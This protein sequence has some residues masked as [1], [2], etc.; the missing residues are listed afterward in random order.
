MSSTDNVLNPFDPPY[1]DEKSLHRIESPLA[2]A[3]HMIKHRTDAS[4]D[5]FLEEHIRKSLVF[6]AW[7]R[8]M[9]SITPDV[10]SRYQKHYR[11]HDRA[12]VN[13]AVSEMQ[14][15]LPVGQVLFHGGVWPSE[16]GKS[17]VLDRPFA[18]TLIPSVALRN[19][20]CNAKAYDAG[21]I[22]LM[23]LTIRAPTVKAFVFRNRRTSQS[24]EHE[25]LLSSG[26]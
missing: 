22:Q 12:A 9:P 16:R 11:K 1:Q 18:T 3:I 7:R 4:L 10:L 15:Y 2:A 23:V 25:V 21:E 5:F 19:A 20:E 14:F 17:F 24:H 8:H 13:K 6:D 26:T